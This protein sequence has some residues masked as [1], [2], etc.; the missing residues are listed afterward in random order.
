MS[1]IL[2]NAS[3]KFREWLFDRVNSVAQYAHYEHG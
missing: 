2:H 3:F 1:T